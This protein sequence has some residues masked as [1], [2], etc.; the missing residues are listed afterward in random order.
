MASVFVLKTSPSSEVFV[1]LDGA[2]ATVI[3]ILAFVI[4]RRRTVS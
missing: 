3:L 2:M 4:Y 1:V